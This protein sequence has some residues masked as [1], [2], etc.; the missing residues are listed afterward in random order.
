[1]APP[2]DAGRAPTAV[3]ASTAVVAWKGSGAMETWNEAEREHWPGRRSSAHEDFFQPVAPCAAPYGARSPVLPP[4]RPGRPLATDTLIQRPHVQPNCGWPVGGRERA[5]RSSHLT[6]RWSLRHI[7]RAHGGWLVG[8][9]L[10]L[11]LTGLVGVV[12]QLFLTSGTAAGVD[13]SRQALAYQA[14]ATD[15]AEPAAPDATATLDSDPT[16]TLAPASTATAVPQPRPKPTPVLSVNP[17]PT[18]TAR[19]TTAAAAAPRPTATPTTPVKAPATA[20]AS[21]RP[22]PITSPYVGATFNT[23]GQPCHSANFFVATISQWA[24]PPGCFATIYTPDPKN[25]PA[26][27]ST[28]GFCNWWVE[29]LHPNTTDILKNPKY[30]RGSTP[31]PGAAI[32]FSPSVQGASSIGHF[33]QVVAIAQDHHWIL[34]TEMN[35]IWRGGGFG[36]IDYRYVQLGAG[37]TFIYT[38]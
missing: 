24:I 23:V 17:T 37:V 28:F 25:Y 20:T 7:L 4:A 9:S 5:G 38:S 2:Q 31:V 15:T 3:G 30:P 32:Y 12:A 8:G 34:V 19:P 10:A 6:G 33:A 13:G 21:P 16:A 35:F 22:T 11:L 26:V 29:E 36:K 27:P 14:P 18:A 1:M